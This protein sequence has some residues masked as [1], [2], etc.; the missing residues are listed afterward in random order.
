[1]CVV[2]AKTGKM[3]LKGNKKDSKFLTGRF[4]SWKDATVHFVK[5]LKTLSHKNAV[6]LIVLLPWTTRDVREV[7]SSAHT[8]EKAVNRDR[9]LTCID[10]S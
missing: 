3:K 1:M 5:Q 10:K 4:S 6:D 2:A 7:Q 9:L 8:A